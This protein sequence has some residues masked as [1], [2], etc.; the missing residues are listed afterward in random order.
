IADTP[1]LV[2]ERRAVPLKALNP[3]FKGVWSAAA[4]F[5][6]LPLLDTRPG[7]YPQRHRSGDDS[8]GHHGPGG[9][10]YRPPCSARASLAY[11]GPLNL[12]GF[13]VGCS[14]YTC[15]RMDHDKAPLFSRD[16]RR[17]RDEM[18]SVSASIYAL[19]IA[20]N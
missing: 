19:Q 15:A 9:S 12:S 3:M 11:R 17:N 14:W 5:V 4:N 2:V 1:R 20:R 10:G 7:Q 16:G 8:L 6:L 13:V 18:L